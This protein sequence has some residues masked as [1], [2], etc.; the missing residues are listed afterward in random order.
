MASTAAILIHKHR[1][2][3]INSGISRRR[4]EIPT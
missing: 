4:S 2:P 1:L 3:I